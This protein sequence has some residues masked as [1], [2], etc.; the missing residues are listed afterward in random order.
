MNENIQNWIIDQANNITNWASAEIP[1]FIQE[2]LAWNFYSGLINIGFCSIILGVVVWLFIKFRKQLLEMFNDC[3]PSVLFIGTGVL[4]AFIILPVAIYDNA[5]EVIQI[6][7]APKVYLVE[8][9]TMM[10][11]RK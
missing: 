5:K 11:K 10:F 3:N 9:A 6:K 1:S 7:V 4:V 8:K 2:F